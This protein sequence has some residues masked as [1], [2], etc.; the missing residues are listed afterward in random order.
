MLRRN[1]RCAPHR[2]QG[3]GHFCSW[4]VPIQALV[5]AGLH[6]QWPIEQWPNFSFDLHARTQRE[7]GHHDQTFGCA[8]KR[9][10]PVGGSPRPPGLSPD[11]WG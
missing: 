8:G 5:L 6:A 10:S 4:H 7:G 1:S 9:Q 2:T 11:G 3:E